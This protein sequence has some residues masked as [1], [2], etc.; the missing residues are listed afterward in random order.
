MPVSQHILDMFIG[1][2]NR[3]KVVR[4]HQK[5]FWGFLKSIIG[6]QSIK[7]FDVAKAKPFF[8][9]SYCHKL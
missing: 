8:V 5:Y 6:N 1:V 4:V 2:S 9:Q 3:N 7:C